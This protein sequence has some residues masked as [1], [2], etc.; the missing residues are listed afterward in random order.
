MSSS[1]SLTITESKMSIANDQNKPEIIKISRKSNVY[2]SKESKPEKY[3][4]EISKLAEN[5]YQ[6]S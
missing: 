3:H 4:I 6:S 5:T 1:S 2:S